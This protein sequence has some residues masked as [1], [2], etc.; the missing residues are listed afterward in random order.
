MFNL[1]QRDVQRQLQTAIAGA[2][3]HSQHVASPTA[4]GRRRQVL[5]HIVQRAIAL[6]LDG[7]VR[8]VLPQVLDLPRDVAKGVAA[9]TQPAKPTLRAF[10]AHALP[11]KD[12]I[13]IQIGKSGPIGLA[14]LVVSGRI[15]QR[16]LP[17]R[18]LD[19]ES[20]TQII[21]EREGIQIPLD[22]EGH[23]LALPLLEGI[24]HVIACA[25]GQCQW[26][27]APDPAGLPF[28]QAP[29]QCQQPGQTWRQRRLGPS[30]RLPV[31][32]Q[33][34]LHIRIGELGLLDKQI[35]IR[36]RPRPLGWLDLPVQH[37]L[38]RCQRNTRLFKHIRKLDPALL[39]GQVRPAPTLVRLKAHVRMSQTGQ[40]CFFGSR[41]GQAGKPPFGAVGLGRVQR[42]FPAPIQTIAHAMR[43]Q[44]AQGRAHP[45][46]QR[47]A[48]CQLSQ[49]GQIQALGLKHPATGQ[50]PDRLVQIATGPRRVAP[51]QTGR[52]ARPDQTLCRFK[53][54]VLVAQPSDFRLVADGHPPIDLLEGQGRQLSRQAHTDFLHIGVDTQSLQLAFVQ[55]Q[56]AIESPPSTRHINGQRH[57]LTQ[58]LHIHPRQGH[59]HRAGPGVPLAGARHGA[60]HLTPPRHRRPLGH[61]H[62]ADLPQGLGHG[63]ID[64]QTLA[65]LR[66]GRRLQG[67]LVPV[68]PQAGP[69]AQRQVDVFQCN[70][71]RAHLLVSPPHLTAI[72][73]DQGL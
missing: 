9:G 45:P 41:P 16:H 61:Q 5:Q 70:R 60:H 20:P 71:W 24:A 51:F 39:N 65:K 15:V 25:A 3:R 11:F 4:H 28:G 46:G 52:T 44:I 14:C 49:Q 30:P 58:A 13:A 64:R 63:H 2:L 43:R 55:R 29:I 48:V 23:V 7:Q 19:P 8:I 67:Q 47:Q 33:R 59:P 1:I 50:L 40:S 6:A 72:D 36:G 32:L 35:H 62:F 17:H 66:R 73:A 12:Q 27:I 37:R 56:L 31:P 21:L 18:H 68:P 22:R 38:H 53:T 26:Q 57:M 42:A 10:N 34:P 54:Q 69:A